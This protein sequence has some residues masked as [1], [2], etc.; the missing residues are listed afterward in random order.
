MHL[1]N[2]ILATKEQFKALVHEYPKG[3]PVVMVNLLKFTGED[4]RKSYQT[5]SRNMAPLLEKAGAKV[6]WSGNVNL[7]VIGDSE[8]QPDM[9]ILVE[10]PSTQHF[11]DMATSAEYKVVGQ[12]REGALVYGGLLAST[13]IGMFG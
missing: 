4:G 11:I 8:D 13:G 7:T 5:Y 2:Q 9:V 3:Q 6:I 12:D 10:Y 1:F